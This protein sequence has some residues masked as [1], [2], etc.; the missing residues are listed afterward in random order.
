MKKNSTQRENIYIAAI[1][2]GKEKLSK[3]ETT[4]KEDLREF[5]TLQGYNIPNDLFLDNLFL[6]TFGTQMMRNKGWAHEKSYLNSDSYFKLLDH[7]ELRHAEESSR[8]AKKW[9][10]I[11]IVISAFLALFSILLSWYE[12]THPTEIYI[13]ETQFEELVQAP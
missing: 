12:I 8:E 6:D 1:Q 4:I 9:A 3:K 11:A 5:L 2:Y 7:E 10:V 13:N